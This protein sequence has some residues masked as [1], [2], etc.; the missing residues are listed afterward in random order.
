MWLLF[1][2]DMVGLIHQMEWKL[3]GIH[4][5]PKASLLPRDHLY[6]SE[7]KRTSNFLAIVNS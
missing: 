5:F 7:K 2:V 6:M 3:R 4:T 1:I